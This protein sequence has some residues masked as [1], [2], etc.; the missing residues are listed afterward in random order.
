M[1][2][3]MRRTTQEERVL[4][5]R[6]I[7][8]K[9]EEVKAQIA[10]LHTTAPIDE[11]LALDERRRA[12]LTQVETLK[13]QR[14]E[15][16]KAVSRTT[17]PAERQA[18]IERLRSLGDEI[19]ALDDKVKMLDAELRDLLLRVP[20]L[21][22]PDV[23]DGPDE[24]A[25][26]VRKCVGELPAF[27]FPPRPHWELGEQ[28]GIIDFERGVKISGS[29]FYVLRGDGARL[30]RALITWMIDL[31]VQKHGYQE[32]YPPFMV[33]EEMLV[34]TGQLPKFADGLF[35]DIYED[36]WMIPT[37][38]VPV[39]NLY[40]DEILDEEQLPIYHVAYTACFRREQISAGRD[41]RG[42]KRGY[43]FD[44]VEMVKF[45][46]P[47][48]SIEEHQRLIGEAEDV[49]KALELPY[50][51]VQMCTGDLSFTAASKYDLEVWAPGS[52]EWLEV[53]SCSN[54]LDFQA[55]RANLRFRPA[56][57]GRPQYLHTL[58]G[59]G[60]ALPRTMIAI[61]ENYQQEDG[62]FRVPEVIRPYLGG[63]EVIGPQPPIGPAR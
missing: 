57:G 52:G 41:V 63:Q 26:V 18:L 20:N 38:E 14:N 5:L 32:V 23:P 50:R 27:A 62:S 10:R 22:L 31:H 19:A 30:Q 11:I 61:I 6:L 43:Q 21:P 36:K 58:N 25:N 37:A 29:R 17:D 53:S 13:A 44:K 35:R 49:L 51:V 15:G 3:Q 1:P 59:S 12:L 7:R 42:I 9:P 4:D 48:R 47:D 60:L 55:R 28:L 16:S 24:S 8:E 46:H 40:R 56:G 33:M 45:V 54:F 2:A 34:G 39:T